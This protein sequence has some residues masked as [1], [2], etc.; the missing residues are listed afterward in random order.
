M[1]VRVGINGFGRIGRLFLRAAKSSGKDFDFVAIND[2]AD[3]G[4][5]ALLLR[6]DSIHGPYPGRVESDGTDLIVDQDRIRTHKVTDKREGDP[7]PFPWGEVGA[8]IVVEATGIFRRIVE[9]E[10]H[11]SAG[12]KKVVLTV[13]SKDPRG[14][15]TIYYCPLNDPTQAR[16]LL[17]KLF[18]HATIFAE[19]AVREQHHFLC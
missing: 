6:Y 4:Q 15:T 17:H 12:A 10:R 19:N 5:L 3:T 16:D 8:E 13:P 2:L 7:F 1:A 14:Q 9:L 18:E 11:L